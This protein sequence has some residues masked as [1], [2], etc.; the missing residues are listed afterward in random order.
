MLTDNSQL[1]LNQAVSWFLVLLDIKSQEIKISGNQSFLN[2]LLTIA[3]SPLDEIQI[4]A[5][6]TNSRRLNTGNVT[7]VSSK[8]I[9]KQPI[10]NPLSAL[11]G[12][13]PGMVITQNTGVSGGGFSVQIRGRN[14]LT[15]GLDP[16]Y[17]VDDV[18]YPSQLVKG[19]GGGILTTPNSGSQGA[20]NPLSFINPLDIE[21]ISVL[22]DADATAIYGSREC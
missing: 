19:N 22:K 1:M 20:G 2:I 16:L 15:S 4:I 6:G 21:S 7:T 10:S 17:I 14:S 3:N 8:E 9:E 11:Q 12:R 13:I 5:Y 18:P